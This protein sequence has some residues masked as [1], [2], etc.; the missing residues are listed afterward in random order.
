MVS[1]TRRWATGQ[2]IKAADTTAHHTLTNTVRV[3]VPDHPG[4]LLSRNNLAFAHKSTGRLDEAIVLHEQNLTD[5]EQALGPDHPDTLA[6]RNNLAAAYNSAGAPS[7]GT[8][9]PMC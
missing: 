4:T 6:S 5:R 3:L 7:R 9:Q 1:A 2:L 8:W